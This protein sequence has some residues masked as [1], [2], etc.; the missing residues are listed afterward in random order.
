MEMTLLWHIS[1]VLMGVMALINIPVI[2]ILSNTVLKALNDYERQI[3]QKKNPVFFS[4]NIDL[5]QK[6]DYWNET[7]CE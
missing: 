1:D 2:L 7:T 6:T 3:R 5:K 4:K